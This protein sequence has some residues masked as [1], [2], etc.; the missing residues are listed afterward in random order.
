MYAPLCRPRPADSLDNWSFKAKRRRTTG[1]G[2]MRHLKH[3]YLRFRHGFRMPPLP[4]SSLTLQAPARPQGCRVL[5]PKPHRMHRIQRIQHAYNTH[6]LRIQCAYT[7]LH[8][9]YARH[10]MHI[11]RMPAYT[12][13]DVHTDAA[14]LRHG[15]CG[16]MH[17]LWSLATC[18]AR[19]PH[20]YMYTQYI[21]IWHSGSAYC[22]S[23]LHYVHCPSPARC[24]RAVCAVSAPRAPRAVLYASA[25]P[26]P[27]A[28]SPCGFR[29]SPAYA[30]DCFIASATLHTP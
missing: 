28:H 21:V 2:R 3:V 5:A 11:C 17:D 13:Y 29:G 18:G 8:M 10:Y 19:A 15:M 24:M 7:R 16:C 20:M 27:P 6:I 12:T 30:S 22:R 26:R 25:A 23:S 1:T 9:A 4:L 14:V